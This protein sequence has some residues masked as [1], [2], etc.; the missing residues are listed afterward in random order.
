MSVLTSFSAKRFD[1]NIVER[2]RTE[3]FLTANGHILA[4]KSYDN[5]QLSKDVYSRR[6]ITVVR[7]E[8]QAS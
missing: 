6:K 5:A 7:Y 4:K 1:V 3:Q 8:L 2:M